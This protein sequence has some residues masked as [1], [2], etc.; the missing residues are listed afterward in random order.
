[1]WSLRLLR[2]PTAAGLHLP[3]LEAVRD[4]LAGLPLGPALALV[5]PRGYIPDFITPPP[6]SPLADIHDELALLRRTPP[7]QVR[8]EIERFLKYQRKRSPGILAG[9]I[10]H[11]RRA[12]RELVDAYEAYWDLALAEHWPRMRALLQGDVAYRGGRLAEGGLERLFDDV[13][14]TVTFGTDTVSVDLPWD[15]ELPLDGRGL[16]LVPSVFA[17]HH[18]AVMIEGPWQPS[19]T[20]P[21]RGVATLWDP[22][23]GAPEGLERLVGP[24]RARM[25][26]VLDQPRSTT[27][28]ARIVDVTAGAISQHLVVL[29]AA[30]LVTRRRDG[31]AMLSVRTPAADAL[32]SSSSS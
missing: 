10:E 26:A 8:V 9:F 23:A 16:L 4:P 28:L 17:W 1:V 11:P 25:L 14:P 18:P 6:S 21:A 22:G 5:P 3:W 29:R 31:R 30:G 13:H 15:G 27:D 2:D 12:V 19:M 7:A 32:V 24:T 20:Y